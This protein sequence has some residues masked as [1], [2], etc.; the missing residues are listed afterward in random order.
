MTGPD[1]YSALLT[2]EQMGRAD[3]LAVEAGISSI[4]LME[5]AGRAVLATVVEQ[6]SQMPVLVLCGPG[7]NGGDGFVVARLLAEAGW[8]VQVALSCDPEK[9][10]GDAKINYHR[11]QGKVH[12]LSPDFLADHSLDNNTLIVDALF[13]AGLDRD[14]TG[15]LARIITA[16]NQSGQPVVAIDMPSGVDG[17]SGQVRGVALRAG[18]TVTFF[19]KKPGHLLYPGRGLCGEVLVRDI[20]IPGSVLAEIPVRTFENAPGL[21]S[22]PLSAADGHKYGRGHCLVVSGDELHTGAARLAACAALR[23]GAGLVTLTGSRAALM[24]HAAHVSAIMLAESNTA[25]GLAALLEDRRKNALVIGPAAGRGQGTRSRVLTALNSGVACVFDADALTSFADKPG[26][27]FQAIASH[28]DRPVVLTPH[29]GEFAALFGRARSENKLERARAAAKLSGAIIVLKGADTVIAAPGGC[30]AI[31]SNAPPALATA[32]S[33][34]VLAGLVGGLLAQGMLGFDAA[35]AAV[36]LHGEAGN[37]FGGP[38]LIADDL[39]DLI[40][41][42]LAGLSKSAR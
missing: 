7:N 39:P 32:G 5:N 34:D 13:G 14:I 40:P 8:P 31:N 11:W 15:D 21:W 17:A 6:N 25:P 1:N 22:V 20:A 38:G 24:I 35:A 4:D 12:S 18:Q 23:V 29:E 37:L 26:K 9:L 30:A 33:G 10:R 36:W 3:A 42:I 41:Q 19:R 28:A 16:L 27:L 2:P